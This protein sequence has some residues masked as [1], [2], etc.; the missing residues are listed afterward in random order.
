MGL[1]GNTRSSQRRHQQLIHKDLDQKPVNLSTM[2]GSTRRSTRLRRGELR[3][4]RSGGNTRTGFLSS[5]RNLQRPGL[6][7][8]TKRST[9]FPQITVGQ[10]YFLIRKR[11]S[12]RPEDALFFFVN[13]VI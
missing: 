7:I 2:S 9:W 6:A 3:G 4:R 1:A 12:L 5:L 13:N 10:F 8:W 11:I